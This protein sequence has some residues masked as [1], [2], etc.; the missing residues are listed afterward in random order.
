MTKDEC[1]EMLRKWGA[2]YGQ[3]RPS[4]W[5]EDS[6]PTGDSPLARAIE[7]APGKKNRRIDAAYKRRSRPGERIWSRD[8]IPCTESRHAVGSPALG[9]R[10]KDPEVS[11]VQSAWLAMLRADPHLAQAIRVE[12]QVRG[13]QSEKAAHLAI[14]RGQYREAVA[15][16]RGWMRNRLSLAIAA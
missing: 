13:T 6:S 14:G 16:G 8:P 7:F 3:G 2:V 4:E 15:E 12:Y 10:D 1:D 9:I 5:E 11:I